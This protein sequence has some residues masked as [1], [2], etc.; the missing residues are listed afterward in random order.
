MRLLT[1][2]LVGIWRASNAFDLSLFLLLP[3]PFLSLPHFLFSPSLLLFLSLL[4]P[5]LPVWYS[6]LL[7]LTL[8][9]LFSFSFFFFLRNEQTVRARLHR[10]MLPF[11]LCPGPPLSTF[12]LLPLRYKLVPSQGA[13]DI[14]EFTQPP[15]WCLLFS[16]TKT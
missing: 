7:L 10:D 16:P 6:L 11:W 3:L 15:S 9:C 5:C 8:S 1:S 13:P 14:L 2:L 12:L 4:P